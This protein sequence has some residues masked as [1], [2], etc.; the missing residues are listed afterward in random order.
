MPTAWPAISPA[1][2]TSITPATWTSSQ[3]RDGASWN[4]PRAPA[5]RAGERPISSPAGE[6]RRALLTP[7]RECLAGI[8]GAR[9]PERVT[10]LHGVALLHRQ[11]LALVERRLAQP[12]R[13]RAVR[14]DVPRPGHRRAAQ[15]G[16]FVNRGQ[17]TEPKRLLTRQRLPGEKHP[18]DHALRQGP[19]HVVAP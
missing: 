16:A 6:S 14:G 17:E 13:Q 7:G 10:L 8:G 1:T 19:H 12:Q 15:L 9:Q 11:R 2:A 3:R 18:P 4:G 5:D